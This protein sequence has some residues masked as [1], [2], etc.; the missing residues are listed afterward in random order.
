MN[1]NTFKR[2]KRND[3]NKVI[4]NDNNFHE[5]LNELKNRFHQSQKDCEDYQKFKEEAKVEIEQ[6]KEEKEKARN[7]S[8][9]LLNKFQELRSLVRDH[10]AILDKFDAKLGD[11]YSEC[12]EAVEISIDKNKSR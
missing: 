6:L 10:K 3:G 1:E 2:A 7:L 12:E 5:T 11:V 8:V 9:F 4:L